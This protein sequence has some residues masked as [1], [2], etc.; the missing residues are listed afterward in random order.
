M[1]EAWRIVKT[2]YISTAFTGEG[3]SLEGGRWNSPG[4]RVVY[5]SSSP[6]LA[7]LETMVNVESLVPL[8]AYSMLRLEFPESLV[9]QLP[10]D[11]LPANWLTYP[12]PVE[13]QGIGDTWV[14]S[15]RTC[16]LAVPSTVITYESNY[17]LNPLH[18]RFIEIS[19]GSPT[20]L[21]INP[22]IAALFGPT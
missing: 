22:R 2:K 20:E 21:E 3:A 18:P 9:E 12:P 16:V 10:R 14:A 17:I 8:P 4:I 13:T 15:A 7:L 5:T 6:S 1:I 19:I 11:A